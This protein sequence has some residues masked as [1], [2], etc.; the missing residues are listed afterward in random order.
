MPQYIPDYTNLCTIHTNVQCISKELKDSKTLCQ[1]SIT[2]A[3]TWL[4]YIVFDLFLDKQN[5]I[6]KKEEINKTRG[7]KKF[8][9][10]LL[11]SL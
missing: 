1:L 5:N 2:K 9:E 4:I 11:L 10:R 7:K 3:K 6:K 8:Y